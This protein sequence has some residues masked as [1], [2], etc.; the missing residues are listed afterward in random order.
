MIILFGRGIEREIKREEAGIGVRARSG[1]DNVY[2]WERGSGCNQYNQ[3]PKTSPVA[4]R[5]T[6]FFDPEADPCETRWPLFSAK[7]DNNWR[8][9][10]GSS[11]A[12]IL[13]PSH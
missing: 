11:G 1:E 13:A 10:L 7:F 3:S 12:G 2:I 4:G 6:L 5:G 8:E 9:P